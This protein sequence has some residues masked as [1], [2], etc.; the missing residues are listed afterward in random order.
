M[1][2]SKLESYAYDKLR[3]NN[4]F[5]FKVK[6]L[7]LLL[8]IN[9][10]KA[11]NL[12][13]ALKKKGAIEKIG[14]AFFAFKDANDFVIALCINHP[15]Y[16][17]FWSALN[18]YGL[19]DQMP[20]KIFLA[21]TKYSKEIKNF[22]YITLSKK[23][24]FGYTAI[25]DITI[26]E[27]EK[28][29]IDS[30]LFPKYAGGIKEIIKCIKADL[31]NLDVKKLLNHATK[32]ESKAVLRR[33]GFI[34]ENL[35]NANKEKSKKIKR[36]IIEKIRKKIGKGYELLDPNL[37]RT[38]NFNKKWLLDINLENDIFRRT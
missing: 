31:N 18:Y 20:K 30:L 8:E 37:K 17:S 34:L 26:A 10:T 5:L 36:H 2:L 22:K 14:K 16:I 1:Q 29:I 24:F 21:T 9:K 4:L 3:K 13:K 38:N 25:G 23:R 11:Y 33:L 28:A 7:R 12:I 15:S 27:K 19:S 6:D 32:I 35:K